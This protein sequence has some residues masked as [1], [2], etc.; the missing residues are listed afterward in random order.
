MR[1]SLVPSLLKVVKDNKT[2]PIIKIFEIANVYEKN[3]D[4]LPKQIQ[5][6][7]GIV[8]KPGA[9]FYEVKGVIEQLFLDL[10]IKNAIFKQTMAGTGATISIGKE[11]LGDIEVLARD[12]IDFELNF[13]QILKHATVKKVYKTISKFPQFVEDLAIIAPEKIQTGEIIETIKAQNELVI[14][15]SLLD[16]YEETRTFHIA[17]QSDSRNLTGKEVGEIREK[18]L[19]ALKEKHNALLKE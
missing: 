18:I 2:H 14:D 3:G 9:S 17:Y 12:T 5:K 15:V 19:K 10:G 11:E 13:E 7:A 8:K 4:G 16:K 1:M 6:I